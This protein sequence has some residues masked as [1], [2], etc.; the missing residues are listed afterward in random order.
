MKPCAQSRKEP[1]NQQTVQQHIA[2]LIQEHRNYGKGKTP[3]QI[4]NG[5]C[6]EFADELVHRL[7]AGQVLEIDPDWFYS[8]PTSA[9]SHA[10][11]KYG[12]KYYDS[13]TPLGVEDPLNLPI[14]KRAKTKVLKL[15]RTT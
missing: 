15:I 4:N 11:V 7:R 12:G 3:W 9:P 14:F 6:Q 13:E 8:D 10:F 5:Y 2:R 1:T